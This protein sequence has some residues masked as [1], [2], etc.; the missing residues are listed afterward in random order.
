MFEFIKRL[1]TKKPI[2]KTEVVNKDIVVKIAMDITA[3]ALGPVYP[4]VSCAEVIKV[5]NV[6]VTFITDSDLALF[7]FYLGELNNTGRR[8]YLEYLIDL[9]DLNCDDY[10]NESIYEFYKKAQASLVANGRSEEI[11]IY[12]QEVSKIGIPDNK[13]EING[14]LDFVTGVDIDGFGTKTFSFDDKA[15]IADGTYTRESGDNDAYHV[16]PLVRKEYFDDG[17]SIVH[18]YHYYANPHGE[19][20]LISFSNDSLNYRNEKEM[21]MYFDA[22]LQLISSDQI[23]FIN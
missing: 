11:P 22:G 13:D 7:R 15:D 12:Y 18:H 8:H 23:K 9:I 16:K 5:T 10:R 1:F 20:L 3:R 21:A 19:S 6:S 14:W 17:N 4:F 2:A